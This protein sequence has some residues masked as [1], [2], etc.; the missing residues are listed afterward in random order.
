[1]RKWRIEDSVEL[2]KIDGWGIG[3]FGVNDKGNIHSRLR[4]VI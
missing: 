1:M 3:Y 2:Y 4:S